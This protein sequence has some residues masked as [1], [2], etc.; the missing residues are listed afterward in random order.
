MWEYVEL[1]YMSWERGSS[2]CWILTYN[3][4]WSD[5][6]SALNELGQE[7]WELASM[8]GKKSAILKRRIENGKSAES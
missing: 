1:K 5:L 3:R 8:M 7:G 4:Y 6:V 2:E